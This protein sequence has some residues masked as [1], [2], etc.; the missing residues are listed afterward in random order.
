MINCQSVPN[1]HIR[2]FV[3][4]PFIPLRQIELISTKEIAISYSL[5]ID[6]YRFGNTLTVNVSGIDSIQT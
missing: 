6:F 3:N 1:T 4:P 2:S 5:T